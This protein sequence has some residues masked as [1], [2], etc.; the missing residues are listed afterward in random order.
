[1][2]LYSFLTKLQL[3]LFVLFGVIFSSILEKYLKNFNEREE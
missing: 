3:V 2:D 1:M